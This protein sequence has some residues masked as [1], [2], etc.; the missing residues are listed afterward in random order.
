[1]LQWTENDEEIEMAVHERLY[2]AEDLFALPRDQKRYAL[3]EGQLI[4]MSP[5]GETHGRLTAQLL[6]LLGVYV[7]QHKLGRVYGAETG[8]KVAENPDTVYGI[9]LAFVANARIQRRENYFVGAPDLAIEVYSPGNTK[10]EMHKK[11]QNLFD[12]GT[13]L[14]WVLYPKSRVVYVYSTPDAITVL[15]ETDT[16]DGGDVVPGLSIKIAD[17]FAVLDE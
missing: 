13:R 7:N 15:H 1:V 2:T 11:V 17:V 14:M 3:V 5:T 10:I 4:E 8:F 6:I 9:D 16:L 12:A